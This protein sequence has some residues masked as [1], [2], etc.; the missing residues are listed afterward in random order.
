MWPWLV[1]P[2]TVARGDSDPAE[3]LG[4]SQA[5]RAQSDASQ[6]WLTPEATA[7]PR[8]RAIAG[9][10]PTC[11]TKVAIDVEWWPGSTGELT[12]S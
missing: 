10:A 11:I 5:Q 8:C 9:H 4:L 6:R 3:P 1:D 7:C 2:I 12:A